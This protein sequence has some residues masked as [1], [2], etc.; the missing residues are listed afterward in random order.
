[1]PDQLKMRLISYDDLPAIA[2]PSGYKLRSYRPGDEA[3]WSDIIN[4]AGHLGE[5]TAETT[6]QVLTVVPKF[7]HE[8]LLFISTEEGAAVATAC[9]WLDTEN[10]WRRGQ[11]HMVAVVPEHQGRKLSY[12][13]SAEVC[14][15]FRNWG[16]PEV[17][18]STDEFR[19]AAVKAYINLGFRPM[20]R[21]YEH[22]DRWIAVYTEYGMEGEANKIAQWKRVLT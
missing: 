2:P 12:W 14:K 17:Y 18:L 10:D 8:G 9:A 7:R 4:R 5:Y 11:L 13:A 22:Y 15:V 6:R 1:M 3:I 19:K 21:N 20:I 16:V